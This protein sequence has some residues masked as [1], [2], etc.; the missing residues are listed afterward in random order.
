[1]L[2][3]GQDGVLGNITQ[4]DHRI[5]D[6]FLLVHGLPPLT[7]T[8]DLSAPAWAWLGCKIL[9]YSMSPSAV[10]F[11]GARL[12]RFQA[13]DPALELKFFAEKDFPLFIGNFQVVDF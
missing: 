5:S 6:F 3:G 12:F 10:A 8:I 4:A 7:F 9:M 2:K 1:M 11:D 13:Q